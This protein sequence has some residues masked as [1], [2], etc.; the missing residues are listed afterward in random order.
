M[1]IYIEHQYQYNFNSKT[2]AKQL[3]VVIEWF[4]LI[5]INENPINRYKIVNYL[6]KEKVKVWR[7]I[8][9]CIATVAID[10]VH[11]LSVLPVIEWLSDL[12]TVQK[13]RSSN[14]VLTSRCRAS[15]RPHH[16]PL[17]TWSGVANS[18]PRR[19]RVPPAVS[20]LVY[21]RPLLTWTNLGVQWPLSKRNLWA[22]VV[23]C[24]R[25]L[26]KPSM[27]LI[28]LPPIFITNIL[29]WNKGSSGS[30]GY[31]PAYF[32]HLAKISIRFVGLKA[33]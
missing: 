8:V 6:T 2:I 13:S 18:I 5:V 17:S 3:I 30:W 28:A 33:F 31:F 27:Y 23:G 22:P 7:G 24:S 9:F 16:G 12:K 14:C 11:L 25:F 4:R 10:Y 32:Y 26:T 1:Q 19:H 29:Q 20:C 15:A 21:R